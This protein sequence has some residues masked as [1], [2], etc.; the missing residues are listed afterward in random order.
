MAFCAKQLCLAATLVLACLV[1]VF[2]QGEQTGM[3]PQSSDNPPA[4]GQTG[5]ISIVTSP[6]KAIVYLGGQKLGLSPVDTAFPSGR[7]TLTIFLDGNELINERVNICAGMKTSI[8]KKLALP[9]GSVMVKTKPI[10]CNCEVSVDGERVGNTNG[11]VLTI[12]RLEIGTHFF[13][14]SSGKRFKEFKVDVLPEQTLELNV[15]FTAKK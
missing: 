10:A 6:E 5:S 2:S 4:R 13:R 15:D 3:C 14:V 11:A 8:E 12:N 7:H 1:P 9:F